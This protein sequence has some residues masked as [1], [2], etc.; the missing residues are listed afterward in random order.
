MHSLSVSVCPCVSEAVC[1]LMLS[2][3]VCLVVLLWEAATLVLALRLKTASS[4]SWGGSPTVFN[5]KYLFC[6]SQS[7]CINNWNRSSG[8]FSITE[9]YKIMCSVHSVYLNYYHMQLHYKSAIHFVQEC[10]ADLS[11]INF[12]YMQS[13]LPCN[14]AQE[15]L[16]STPFYIHSVCLTE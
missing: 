2:V 9:F 13:I 7:F 11:G 3:W 15:C 4:L 6:I 10:I 1:E 16:L 8:R 12:T 5:L 14:S